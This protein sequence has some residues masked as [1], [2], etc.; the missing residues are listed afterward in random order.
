MS[1]IGPNLSE[2]KLNVI[3]I[4]LAEVNA[5][6]KYC[7][8]SKP[9]LD[10]TDNHNITTDTPPASASGTAV[11]SDYYSRPSLRQSAPSLAPASTSVSL[12]LGPRR[13]R[14]PC[15][16]CSSQIDESVSFLSLRDHGEEGLVRK[17]ASPRSVASIGN[18][19]ETEA[20]DHRQYMTPTGRR[21]KTAVPRPI[22]QLQSPPDKKSKRKRILEPIMKLFK[23]PGHGEESCDDAEEEPEIRPRATEM[24]QAFRPN[25]DNSKTS[26]ETAASLSDDE[27][28][29]PKLAIDES[30]A[31]LRRAQKLLDKTNKDKP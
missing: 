28:K 3:I 2:A 12:K 4:W 11:S 21:V 15:P 17:K 6:R 10:G 30:A 23:R 20:T 7:V 27:C 14:P 1:G 19:S 29:R 8:C 22:Q 31:R 9:T 25:A 16:M 26:I 5:A 24:Y 13:N 18:L